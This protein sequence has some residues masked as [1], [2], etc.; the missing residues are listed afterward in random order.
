[1]TVSPCDYEALALAESRDATIVTTGK[2]IVLYWNKGAEELFGYVGAET[3]GRPLDE[4]I[5]PAVCAQEASRSLA[6]TLTNG[7]TT[8]EALRQRKDG[9]FVFVNVSKKLLSVKDAAD[10]LV[11]ST[12]RDVTQLKVL[13]DAKLMEARF[14]ELLESTPDGIIMANSTGHIVLANSQAEKLFGYAPSELRGKQVEMLLPVRYRG[15]HVAHRSRYFSQPRTR[16]MGAGLELHGLHKIGTEFPV[17]ISLSPLRTEEGTVVMSA[18]RDIT[19]RKKAEQKFRALLESAPDAIVIVNP[20]GQIVIVNSQTEKL[21]GYSRS[22]LLQQEIELLLPERYRRKHPDHRNGFFSDPRVRPMGVGLELYGRRKDGSEF[23][24]EISLS[25]LETEE[26]VLVSSAI[27]DITERK[28]FEQALREKNLE[29]QNASRAKDS[30]LASMSHELRTPLNAIIG[31]TG[32]LLMKLPGPLNAE[33]DKQLRTIQT[34]SKHLLSLINDLLDVAKIEA[35]KLELIREPLDCRQVVE[36]VA[37]ALRLQAELKG[38]EFNVELPGYPLNMLTDRRALSQIVMNLTN[39]AIKFTNTGSVRL[40]L[41]HNHAADCKMLRITVSDTGIGI[42]AADRGKL[43][44]A[45]SRLEFPGRS[46]FEGTGLGLHLSKKLAELLGGQI[47]F[48][49]EFGKGSIFTLVLP[50]D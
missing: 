21:F 12:Q 33:Q 36:E 27:R 23:P 44:I 18:I 34:S 9:S 11:I 20:A 8:L 50:G 17:E 1:V 26:G 37:A 5:V 32:I 45:F 4:L 13:R 19:G 25:P 40:T 6:E 47:T 49:S 41:E 10:P 31:F 14:S 42:R 48:E 46:K 3:L 29:L 39:N 43:F 15:A 28:R 22:E 24:I 7:F 16:S 30:F 38:L 2:G 35:D